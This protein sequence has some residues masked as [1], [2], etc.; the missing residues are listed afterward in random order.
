MGSASWSD[1]SGPREPSLRFFEAELVGLEES[2]VLTGSL[3]LAPLRGVDSS[4]GNA[5]LSSVGPK[6]ESSTS[7]ARR[8]LCCLLLGRIPSRIE[9]SL[10]G[11]GCAEVCR[12]IVDGALVFGVGPAVLDS[13]SGE[14]M[15]WVLFG[16]PLATLAVRCLPGAACIICFLLCALVGCDPGWSPLPTPP[17]A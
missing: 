10:E 4:S 2:G 8:I 16:E 13:V 5:K 7:G 17:D 11:V 3:A 6:L 12:T 9:L 15:P 14:W 1:P